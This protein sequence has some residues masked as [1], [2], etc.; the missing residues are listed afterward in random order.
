[1]EGALRVRQAWCKQVSRGFGARGSIPV[2][3]YAD[4]TAWEY[5]GRYRVQ[6]VTDGG[7][8]AAERRRRIITGRNVRYVIRLE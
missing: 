2:Y 4:P 6:N 8:E 7:P 5:L 1:M 3:R